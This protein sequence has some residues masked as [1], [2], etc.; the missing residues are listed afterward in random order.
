MTSARDWAHF[1]HKFLVERVGIEPLQLGLLLLLLLSLLTLL[2][3]MAKGKH[4]KWT[5]HIFIPIGRD[6]TK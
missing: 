5:I 6:G 4:T 2:V 1:W 3:S